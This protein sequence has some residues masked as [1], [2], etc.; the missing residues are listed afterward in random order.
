MT[1]FSHFL[2]C[3]AQKLQR[4][5]SLAGEPQ[6]MITAGPGMMGPGY[7]N[8]GY[9]NNINYGAGMPSYQGYSM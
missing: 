6:L 8:A 1:Y 2:Y 5:V 3:V 7:P 9:A 4:C